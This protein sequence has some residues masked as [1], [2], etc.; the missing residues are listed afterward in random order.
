MSAPLD[1]YQDFYQEIEKEEF[2]ESL[3]KSIHQVSRSLTETLLETLQGI[4]KETLLSDLFHSLFS[5]IN[6]D[7]LL[8]G[9][10]FLESNKEHL[11]KFFEVNITLFIGRALR[12]TH[13]LDTRSQ[14]DKQTLLLNLFSN[15]THYSEEYSN[16]FKEAMRRHK[17]KIGKKERH[18]V[19]HKIEETHTPHLQDLMMVLFPEGFT[20]L[21]LPFHPLVN[22]FLLA[23][24]K[25][26]VH[27]KGREFLSSLF[28][29]DTKDELKEAL[30]LHA[31]QYSEQEMQLTLAKRSVQ[32][33]QV[34][35]QFSLKLYTVFEKFFDVYFPLKGPDV[36]FT[37]K[38]MAFSFFDALFQKELESLSFSKLFLSL[39]SKILTLSEEKYHKVSGKEVDDYLEK[40]ASSKTNLSLLQKAFMESTMEKIPV[41][42]ATDKNE[43]MKEVFS[44][45]L[46][47][48]IESATKEQAFSGSLDQISELILLVLERLHNFTSSSFF[49][50]F[51][52]ESFAS[53]PP[54]RT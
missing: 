4:K 25:K 51:C 50:R 46:T 32:E 10:P 47:R 35:S 11:Y 24:L 16:A 27:E 18:L 44:T 28:Q 33:F 54:Y 22:S 45:L 19:K 43:M 1:L 21:Y 3:L 36:E 31:V 48:G 38:K 23:Q 7:L 52:K 41:P 29:G 6:K 14:E 9:K 20:S 15:F 13:F 42:Q 40:I 39:V 2:G 17:E 53:F 30:F 26:M 49:D 5:K 8:M 34:D 12:Y 37:I